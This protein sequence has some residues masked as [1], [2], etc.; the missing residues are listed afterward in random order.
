MRHPEGSA[1]ALDVFSQ[2]FEQLLQLFYPFQAARRNR[3]VRESFLCL[4]NE[5]QRCVIALSC[6]GSVL[7]PVLWI[8]ERN[9]RERKAG[10]HFNANKIVHVLFKILLIV[11]ENP[12]VVHNIPL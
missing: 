6:V 4:D 3:M 5:A 10:L 8:A 2:F 9:F 12:V 7:L 11:F 1:P